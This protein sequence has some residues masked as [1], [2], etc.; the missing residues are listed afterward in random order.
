MAQGVSDVWN[1]KCRAPGEVQKE[2]HKVRVLK[3]K[4][5]IEL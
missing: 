2:H 1:P 5:I 3:A 4:Q